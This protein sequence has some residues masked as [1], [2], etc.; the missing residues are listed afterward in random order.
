MAWIEPAAVELLLRTDLSEDPYIEGFI[1]HVQG[2]AEIEVGTQDEPSAGLQAVFAEIVAR[3]YQAS[4]DAVTNPTGVSQESIGGYSWSRF[5]AVGMGLTDAE[6]KA[7]RKAAG[8]S[9]IWVQPI[10]RG[11]QLETAGLVDVTY[12]DGQAVH[13][14]SD[15]EAP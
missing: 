14:Y 13:W 11:D 4:L 8:I 3:K 7:L 10:T 6:K 1:D 2:L 12:P 15:T 9:G 5:T